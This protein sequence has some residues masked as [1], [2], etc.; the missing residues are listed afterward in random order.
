M[1]KRAV[2]VHDLMQKNYRYVCSEKPGEGF[3]PAFQPELTPQE[4]LELGV[5]GGKYFLVFPFGLELERRGFLLDKRVLHPPFKFQVVVPVHVDH[6]HG[7]FGKLFLGIPEHFFRGRV[8]SKQLP[9]RGDDK[10]RLFQGV[11]HAAKP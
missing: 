2:I 10:D 11:V 4:M 8:D 6:F 7:K 5:F 3:D 9:V 1:N